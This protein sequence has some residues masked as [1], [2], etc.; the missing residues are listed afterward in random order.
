M[1][2]ATCNRIKL[3]ESWLLQPTRR[4]LYPGHGTTDGQHVVRHDG[5]YPRRAARFFCGQGDVEGD[6]EEGPSLQEEQTPYLQL[7]LE[8]RL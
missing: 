5:R 3:I 1:L 2:V 4:V 7:L 8:G 6:G